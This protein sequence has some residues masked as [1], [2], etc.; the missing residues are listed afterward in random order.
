MTP[1]DTAFGSVPKQ[2][3]RNFLILA[4]LLI[5]C[6]LK[7]CSFKRTLVLLNVA[8]TLQQETVQWM[9]PS[10]PR[11]STYQLVLRYAN[12]GVPTSSQAPVATVLQGS[13]MYTPRFIIEPSCVPPCHASSMFP[14][15][16]DGQLDF[17]LAEFDL[18]EDPVTVTLELSSI[19]VLIVSP[20]KKNSCIACC[21]P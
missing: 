5:L 8:S 6:T 12:I 4:T 20:L 18:S 15:F 19:D 10:L 17:R 16:M 9:F 14:D 7:R 3:P 13:Q 21:W 1:P 11:A 2:C